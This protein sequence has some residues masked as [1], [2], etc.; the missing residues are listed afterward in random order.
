MMRK[1]IVAWLEG[2]FVGN[3]INFTF[4]LNFTLISSLENRDPRE[5]FLEK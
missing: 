4:F 5:R 1:I 2:D 3:V